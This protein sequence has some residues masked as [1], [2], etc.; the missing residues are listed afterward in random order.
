MLVLCLRS[1]GDAGLYLFYST[2]LSYPYQ[3]DA[4]LPDAELRLWGYL[5]VLPWVVAVVGL[6]LFDMLQLGYPP[7]PATAL[8]PALPPSLP[9]SPPPPSPPPPPPPPAPSPAPPGVRLLWPPEG[10][11]HAARPATLRI[12]AGGLRA[13]DVAKLVPLNGQAL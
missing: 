3:G 7:D 2:I 9:P 13:G 10:T 5:T 12:S 11:L 1:R 8:S 4:P 6:G